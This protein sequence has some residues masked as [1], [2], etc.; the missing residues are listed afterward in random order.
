MRFVWW[1][2]VDVEGLASEFERDYE[3]ELRQPPK[4]EEGS[5]QVNI[6]NLRVLWVRADTLSAFLSRFQ[7]VLFQ[8]EKAPFTRK[9]MALRKKIFEI[10]PHSRPTPFPFLVG[11]EPKFEVEEAQL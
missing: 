1:G 5:M 9:D 11:A 2:K 10:Y 4:K 8:K 3:V 6:D 7:A